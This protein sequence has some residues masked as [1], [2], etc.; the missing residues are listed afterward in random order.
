MASDTVE[1]LSKSI[2]LF[3]KNREVDILGILFPNQ[4]NLL[5]LLIVF[6]SFLNISQVLKTVL[7]LLVVM[8]PMSTL[9]TPRE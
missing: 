4:A 6:A 9:E 8:A 5:T 1:Q 2:L 3:W 7:M